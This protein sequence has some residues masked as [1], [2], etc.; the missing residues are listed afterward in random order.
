MSRAIAGVA[1]SLGSTIEMDDFVLLGLIAVVFFLLGPI[2]FF[3]TLGARSRLRNVETQLA[4]LLA[5]FPRISLAIPPSELR[6]RPVSL[7]N[8][9][10]SLPVRSE[11]GERGGSV[12]S[13][14]ALL[15]SNLRSDCLRN[16]ASGVFYQ[17]KE[18]HGLRRKHQR[19]SSGTA[20]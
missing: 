9:L 4:A 19:R 10:E 3:L 6:W 15:R 8:G 12:A 17:G 5:R 7:M 18:V 1:V 16:H 13:D 11:R 2:G 20:S 14:K